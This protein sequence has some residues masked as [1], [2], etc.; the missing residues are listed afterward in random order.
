MRIEGLRVAG[1]MLLEVAVVEVG[2]E[3]ERAVAEGVEPRKGPSKSMS[4][5]GA[6]PVRGEGRWFAFFPVATGR[7]RGD[8]RGKH[9]VRHEKGL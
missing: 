7:N 9:C 4:F 2:V 3:P 1:R 5:L 8:G 6:L